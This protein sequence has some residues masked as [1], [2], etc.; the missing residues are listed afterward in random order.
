MC[1]FGVEVSVLGSVLNSVLSSALIV[2]WSVV[3]G[4]CSGKCFVGVSVGF[5]EFLV[6][7]LAV[8]SHV[9]RVMFVCFL[10]GFLVFQEFLWLLLCLLCFLGFS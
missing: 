2:F 6:G 4:W 10:L 9:V 5:Q 1:F 8:F 3:F 7:V